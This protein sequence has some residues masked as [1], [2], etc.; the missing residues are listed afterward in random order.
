ME[1]VVILKKIFTEMM[2]AIPCRAENTFMNIPFLYW[3]NYLSSDSISL[4]I[5][6]VSRL[7]PPFSSEKLWQ[8]VRKEGV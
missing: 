6:V 3:L 4:G 2:Y 5:W 7:M 8:Q 1:E